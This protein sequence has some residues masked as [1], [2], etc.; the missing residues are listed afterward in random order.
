MGQ[1]GCHGTTTE[2]YAEYKR[3]AVVMQPTP[4]AEVRRSSDAY[5]HSS[6]R[7]WAIQVRPPGVARNRGVCGLW[8][9]VLG[10]SS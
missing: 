9:R 1:E 6:S 4:Q 10:A 2:V 8:T 5:R 3:E 7:R